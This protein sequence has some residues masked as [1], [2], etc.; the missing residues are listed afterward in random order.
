M[1]ARIKAIIALLQAD[2]QFSAVPLA[3][4]LIVATLVATSEPLVPPRRT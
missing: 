4:L 3:T 2:P 1:L